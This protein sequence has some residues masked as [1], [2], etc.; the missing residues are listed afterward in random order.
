MFYRFLQFYHGLFPKI[1]SE[2]QQLVQ[3]FLSGPSLYLFQKQ[4]LADQRHALDVAVDLLKNQAYLSF[5]EKRTLIQAALLH[6][7]GKTRYPL[8]LW[9]RVY[10]VLCN[11]LPLT[12]QEFLRNLN[13]CRSLSLPLILAQQHPKWGALLASQAGL[14]EYVI[15]LIRTHHHPDSEMGKLLY[16]ADNRH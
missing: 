15:E 16:D 8:K 11:K 7:C 10:I 3:S 14:T 1:S 9:Q 5:P 2:D 6:D 13:N 4:S 12:T